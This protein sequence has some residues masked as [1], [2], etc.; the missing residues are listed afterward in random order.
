VEGGSANDY[1]YTSGDPVN[2]FDLDGRCGFGNPFKKCGPGHKGG[3]NIVSG[4]LDRGADVARPVVNAPAS[5]AAVAYAY[6]TG[7]SCYRRSGISACD[8]VPVPLAPQVTVGDAVLNSA[9]G[10]LNAQRW[11]HKKR[12]TNQWAVF[13]GGP[14]FVVA[15]GYDRLVHLRSGCG[16]FEGSA[17]YRSG[18][19]DQCVS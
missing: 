6:A 13:G 4:A 8:G 16:W 15:Y 19:Y 3:T 2:S 11:R 18:G 10:P 9:R 1:D 14:L 12:H 7:G 17:G 5:A